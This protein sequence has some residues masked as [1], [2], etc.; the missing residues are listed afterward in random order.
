M[1][2]LPMNDGEVP[3]LCDIDL[4]L[5]SCVLLPRLP[6]PT[7]C[8]TS[9]STLCSVEDAANSEQGLVY[10]CLANHYMDL[11]EGCQ[12]E[13]GRAVHMAFFVW[14]EGA[15]LT[16][17]CD[18]DVK[19]HCLSV[20]PNMAATPGAVGQCLASLVR[21]DPAGWQAHMK[22]SQWTFQI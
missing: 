2:Q 5:G 19:L 12:K 1:L 4:L 20:R 10:K 14:A 7:R 6:P 17:D 11:D 15:I 21:G 3:I 16:A 9:V 13:L 18:E 22:H 8:R